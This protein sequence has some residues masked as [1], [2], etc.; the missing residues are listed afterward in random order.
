[1]WGCWC[2]ASHTGLWAE[3]LWGSGCGQ[4]R[5]RASGRWVAVLTISRFMVSGCPHGLPAPLH[6]TFWGSN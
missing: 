4:E 6:R 3:C 5:R 2:P 1:M